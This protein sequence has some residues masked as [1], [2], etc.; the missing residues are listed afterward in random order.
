MLGILWWLY[1]MFQ[2]GEHQLT[3]WIAGRKVDGSPLSVAGY[4][5]DKVRLEPLGGGTPGQPVQFVG[6]QTLTQSYFLSIPTS[7]SL[8]PAPS[9]TFSC[10]LLWQF[11][12][13]TP[14]WWVFHWRDGQERKSTGECTNSAWERGRGR[15]EWKWGVKTGIQQERNIQSFS[16]SLSP[17]SYRI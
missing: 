4:S 9:V 1:E 15:D 11:R 6:K 10:L 14:F 3:V 8:F 17:L 5:A 2:V 7:I 13:Q 16:L 12:F